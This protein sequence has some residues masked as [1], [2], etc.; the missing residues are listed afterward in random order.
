MR[1]IDAA[2]CP[3]CARV[4][5]VLAEKAVT[6]ETVEID[7]GNRPR[8]VY[9]LNPAGKVPI[10]EDEF[11]LPESD[12]IM[13]YLEERVPEPALLPSEPRARAEARLAVFR[14]DELLG[15][16]YYRLRR[17]EENT[18]AEQLETLPVG[19][20]LFVDFAYLPWVMRLR[21]LYGVT[22]PARLE[23]W[24]EGLLDRPPI[25]AELAVVRGLA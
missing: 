25:A 1:L 12:L 24:L 3:F 16:Q 17:G 11:V 14:F 6:F 19:N 13:E 22:L 2:R 23:S 10:L 4:R 15:K 21:E 9:E 18:V 8:W 20:S 7:L 5:L